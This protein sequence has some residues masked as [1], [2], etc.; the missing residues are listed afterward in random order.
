MAVGP[1]LPAGMGFAGGA[2]LALVLTEVREEGWRTHPS[3][4]L[5]GTLLGL[6]LGVLVNVILPGPAGI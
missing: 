5:V 3:G 6:A 1:F 2:M 4:F